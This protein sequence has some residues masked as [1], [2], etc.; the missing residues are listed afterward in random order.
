MTDMSLWRADRRVERA[1]VNPPPRPAAKIQTPRATVASARRDQLVEVG[2]FLF[3]ILPYMA[4]SFFAVKQ[5][6]LGFPL[7]A[8]STILRDLGLVALILFLMA[9][10]GEPMAAL[11]WTVRRVM[12]EVGLGAV[13]FFPLFLGAQA[14]ER[15]LHSAG[16]SVPSTPTPDLIPSR[17]R[18]T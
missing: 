13:L 8:V 16:L 18:S 15:A 9:R 4:L 7:V 2:V 12:P 17:T 1:D 5:G 6:R 14:L 11:G 3:L 10:D